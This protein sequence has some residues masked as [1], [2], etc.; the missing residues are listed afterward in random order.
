MKLSEEKCAPVEKG[1]PPLSGGQTTE[2]SKQ[3]PGWSLKEAALERDYKFK[4]FRE[5]MEFVNEV[6]AIAASEDHHPD[7]CVSYNKVSLK[8]TTHKIGGLS[9][10][11]FIVAAR[12]DELGLP[13]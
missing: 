9:R 11:D 1:Q 2:L 5:A 8:L 13:E 4:G 6:A 10:N 12:I 7:I 3:V